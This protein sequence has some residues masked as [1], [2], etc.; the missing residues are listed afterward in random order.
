MTTLACNAT[1]MAGDTL[2]VEENHKSHIKT[3]V[4][5]INGWLIGY[6]GTLGECLAFL[7]EV[8]ESGISPLK[9]IKE[10][11][12]KVKD[13]ELLLLSP[14]GKMYT[15][16]GQAPIPVAE[17]YAAIGTGKAYALTAMYLERCPADA[18]SIASVFDVNTDGLTWTPL[19]RKP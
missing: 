1:G 13:V 18:V 4:W 6:A 16:E 9:Y 5:R 14:R 19:R 7:E 12:V 8:K 10:R 2:V 17:E 11:D 3:K 15:W